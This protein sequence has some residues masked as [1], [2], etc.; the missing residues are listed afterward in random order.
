MLY[1]GF[2]DVYP[3]FAVTFLFTVILI[4]YIPNEHPCHSEHC[5]ALPF[6]YPLSNIQEIVND[7]IKKG[8]EH[9]GKSN[10]TLKHKLKQRN[11]VF[12]A[13]P[14]FTVLTEGS[15]TMSKMSANRLLGR[16]IVYVD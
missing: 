3:F 8:Y 16:K 5:T 9:E 15:S 1:I 4:Y 11:S 10:I 2:T 13:L 7:V 6:T 14:H 12:T